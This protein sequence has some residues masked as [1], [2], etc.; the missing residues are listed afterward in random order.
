M[1]WASPYME[2]YIYLRGAP[3]MF[4][5]LKLKNIAREV[6]DPHRD[7]DPVDLRPLLVIGIILF[8]I[9]LI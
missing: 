4:D 2:R 8:L 7:R 1:R 3:I 5:S 9:W 6:P